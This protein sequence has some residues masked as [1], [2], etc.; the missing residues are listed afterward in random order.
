MNSWNTTGRIKASVLV[1]V[2]LLNIVIPMEATED[3]F[4]NLFLIPVIFTLLTTIVLFAS[5]VGNRPII[6]RPLWN[7]SPWNLKRPLAL[8]D[9]LSFFFLIAGLGTIIGTLIRHQSL[10]NIGMA[11]LYFGIGIQFGIWIT[12]KWAERKH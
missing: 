6:T 9:F 7:E 8:F 11:F 4:F 5:N 12:L 1:I 2:A 3:S 10:S